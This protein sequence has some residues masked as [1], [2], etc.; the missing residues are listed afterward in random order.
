[1][2]RI[3]NEQSPSALRGQKIPEG[4]TGIDSARPENSEGA[5][6]IAGARSEDSEGANHVDAQI[7]GDFG[8]READLA[9]VAARLPVPI[10]HRRLVRVD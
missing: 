10:S 6:L 8:W 7:R 1:V 5:N 9:D 4:A 3:P 2:R